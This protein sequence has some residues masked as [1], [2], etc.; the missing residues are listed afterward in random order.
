M[1][2]YDIIACPSCKGPVNQVDDQLTCPSCSQVYP[3]V[4]GVPVMLL[5]GSIPETQYQEQLQLRQS[6]DPWVHRTILQSLSDDQIVLEIGAGNMA[7]DDPCIIRSDVTLTPYVDIVADVH[8]LPFLPG[9]I[10]YI[11]SLAVFEHLRNPFLASQSIYEALKDGG[12][13]YHECNFV[14]AY[15]GYPHH[16]FNATLQGMEQIFDQF[17][18]LRKGV[19]PYQMPSFALN[20]VLGSYLQHSRAGEFQH[21]Q[22]LVA[23]IANVLNQDLMAHDIYFTEE[24]ALITAAGTYFSGYKQ[25]TADSSLIPHNIRKVRENEEELSQRF[26]NINDLTNL[27]NIMLWAKGEGSQTHPAIADY[28]QSIEPFAKS[29]ES[30]VWD[31]SHIHGLDIAPTPYGAIGYN[32]M[33]ASMEELAKL[34]FE[35]DT[36]RQT[37]A[38]SE[39]LMDILRKTGLRATI[40]EILQ[41][42]AN[43]L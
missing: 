32:T 3:I 6:Y 10:D 21:G 26:R 40:K 39:P 17:T 33:D 22:K 43:R 37:T 12:Y 27:D 1:N 38:D 20:A 18:S 30:K 19:A 41:R 29:G 24:S 28:F 2:L 9:T 42:I 5:D 23:A 31:R 15:H 4:N 25:E 35:A 7:L 11:F 13:I 14:F 34:V 36:D 8:A 16:Y